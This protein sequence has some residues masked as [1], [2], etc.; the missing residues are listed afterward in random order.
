M[1]FKDFLLQKL[2]RAVT[3]SPSADWPIYK[4]Y[5]LRVD[6]DAMSLNGIALG[7]KWEDAKALGRPNLTESISEKHYQLF[8]FQNG[9]IADFENDVLTYINIAIGDDELAPHSKKMIPTSPTVFGC[10][11]QRTIL[12]HNTSESQIRA[13]MGSPTDSDVDHEESILFYIRNQAEIEF[14]FSKTGK[15]KWFNFYRNSENDHSES[16]RQ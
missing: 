13:W 16:S 15:L 5:E 4:R 1:R 8:Y 7:T 11:L 9:F 14:E 10:D 12:T 6:L 2:F 3:N